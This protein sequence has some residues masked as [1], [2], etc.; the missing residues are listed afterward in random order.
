M[1]ISDGSLWETGIWVIFIFLFIFFRS[2]DLKMS[3]VFISRNKF[4]E[5]KIGVFGHPPPPPPK[6]CDL[7]LLSK[8]QTETQRTQGS[9]SFQDCA[10]CVWGAE[11]GEGYKGMGNGVPALMNSSSDLEED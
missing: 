8:K 9:C 2:L 1:L 7:C 3:I 11:Q 6:P 5:K 10:G 4:F